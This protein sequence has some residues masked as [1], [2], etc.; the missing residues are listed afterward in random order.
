ME[1]V[2]PGPLPPSDAAP[3]M[4]AALTG[5]AAPQAPD[6]ADR[7]PSAVPR[8]AWGVFLLL[9]AMQLLD[10]VDRWLLASVLRQVSEELQITEAKAGWLSTVLL[11]AFA[12]FCPVAGYL[13]D[14]MRRPRLLA[15]GFAVWSL[16]TVATGLASSFEQLEERVPWWE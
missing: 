12:I 3:K 9:V 6:Q 1:Q 13:A 15:V 14:R 2:T 5:E 10:S 8:W 7:A 16:S 11:L 4:A